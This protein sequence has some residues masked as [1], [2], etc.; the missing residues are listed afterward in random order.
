MKVTLII[1]QLEEHDEPEP[2]VLEQVIYGDEDRGLQKT[3]MTITYDEDD[4][5]T[6]MKVLDDIVKGVEKHYGYSF[7]LEKLRDIS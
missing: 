1:D 3:T 4:F 7:D 5:T 2:M 6:W